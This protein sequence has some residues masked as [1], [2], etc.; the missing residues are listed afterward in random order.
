MDTS[1]ITLLPRENE[2]GLQV[3]TTGGEWV[4]PD[5]PDGSIVVNFGMFLEKVSNGRVRATPH[6]V[7]PPVCGTRYSMPLFMC[8]QLDAQMG[9]LPTCCDADSPPEASAETFWHFHT[10][11]MAKIY[12]HFAAKEDEL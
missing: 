4:W 9:V 2:P 10:A 6:R 7:I 3:M 1:F 11:H 12:P 5:C 8:P